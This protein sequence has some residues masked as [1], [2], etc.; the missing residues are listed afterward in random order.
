MKRVSNNDSLDSV[1]KADMKFVREVIN[2]GLGTSAS[3]NNIVVHWKASH[4]YCPNSDEVNH[5]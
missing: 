5:L 2:C 3:W 4:G 1:C